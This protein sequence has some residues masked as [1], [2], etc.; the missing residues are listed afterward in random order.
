M[1]IYLYKVVISSAFVTVI[2]CLLLH[3]V[4]CDVISD[5]KVVGGGGGGGGGGL[6]R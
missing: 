6:G 4:N 2:S 1:L 5:M 3:H